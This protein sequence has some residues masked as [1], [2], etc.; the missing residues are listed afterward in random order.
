MLCDLSLSE[1]VWAVIR[2]KPK[3]EIF[4]KDFFVKD[5]FE[6]YLPIIKLK[7]KETKAKPL[8][9]GYVFTKLSPRFDISYIKKSPNVLCPLMFKEQLAV[10]EEET[11]NFFKQRQDSSGVIYVEKPNKFK[12]GQKV[13]ISKGSFSGLEGVVLEYL[14]EKERVRLLLQYF[15][16]EINIEVKES[17]LN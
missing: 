3:K 5:G 17:I 1:K 16:R 15:G 13:K 11:I 2:S 14:K 4:V 12:R 9:P 10:L 7:G 8:F 6:V